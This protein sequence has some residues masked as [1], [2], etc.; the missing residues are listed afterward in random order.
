MNQLDI[1]SMTIEE[2]EDLLISLQ[3]PKFRAKQIFDWLHV[4]KVLSFTEMTNLP[5]ALIEVLEQRCYITKL[6]IKRKLVSAIDGT[7]KYLFKL[8]DSEFVESVIMKYKHGNSICISTQVGCKMGCAFCASTK[9]GFVRN[10][11]PSEILEQIYQASKDIGERISNVVLMGIGEPLDNYDNVV[12]FLHLL[13]HEKGHNLSLRHVSLSTCGV[14]DKIYELAK[15]KLGLTL[16]ISL[17]AP[18]DQIRSQTMPIN[19]RYPISELLQA[20]RFY[21]EQTGRRISFEYALI[22]GVNDS[23]ACANQLASL[24][25]GMLCHVNLI[26]VNEIRETNF[27]TAYPKNV[28]NFQKWLESKGIN[29]TI[30]RTLGADINAAC[31]QLRRDN[32]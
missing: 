25:K 32:L 11:T 5:K 22:R 4:K 9:A 7:T 29:T 20:C 2:L 21:T 26:P 31:G 6:T 28:V 30:R 15:L 3:Q 12:R 10:L 14:V 24:L 18:N 17:H 27:K 19:K 1:K 23:E 16:S 13:S 8:P